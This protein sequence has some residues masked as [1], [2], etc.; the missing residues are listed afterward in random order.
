MKN[1]K[2]IC[3]NI[4]ACSYVGLYVCTHVLHAFFDAL[5]L[6]KIQILQMLSMWVEVNSFPDIQM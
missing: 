6:V 5:K 2:H 4:H 3:T 1:K